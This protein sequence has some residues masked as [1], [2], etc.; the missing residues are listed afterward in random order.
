MHFFDSPDAFNK[1]SDAFNKPSDAFNKPS[2]ASDNS[3]D[4]FSARSVSFPSLSQQL[5]PALPCL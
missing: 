5:M 1:P 2:D 3:I 4:E